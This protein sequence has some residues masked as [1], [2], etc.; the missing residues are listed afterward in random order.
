MQVSEREY[1]AI[2]IV[3]LNSDLG[4]DE[5]CKMW[6]KMNKSR[7][8]K[9]LQEEKK[10]RDRADLIDRAWMIYFKVKNVLD[11][12]FDRWNDD[13]SGYLNQREQD[14]MNKLGV[15][16]V[17]QRLGSVKYELAQLLGIA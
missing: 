6:V 17:Y 2:E 15:K 9:A 10:R 7:V 5:F 16:F 8:E 13:C 3:Y 4:K 1:E 12:D 11:Y 14:V